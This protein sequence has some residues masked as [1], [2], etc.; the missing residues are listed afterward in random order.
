MHD[1]QFTA[2]GP[3][4]AGSGFDRSGFSTNEDGDGFQFGVHV[5]A[6]R[7]GVVGQTRGGGIAGVLGQ[8]RFSQ[9]GVMGTAF[10]QQT[11]VV[12]VS[13]SNTNDLFQLDNQPGDFRLESLGDGLGTG[14]LGKST[15]S[16]GVHG[17]SASNT[18]VF[19]E[20]ESG[21]GGHGKSGS[22][23]GVFGQSDTGLGVHGHSE[24]VTG[25]F[26]DSPSG[27]GVHGKSGSFNGVV[28]ESAT[29]IGVRGSSTDGLGGMFESQHGA[30]IRLLPKNLASPEGQISGTGGELV[31]TTSTGQSGQTFGLWFCTRGGDAA[32]AVWQ[33]VAGSRPFPG[34]LI[35]LNSKGIDVKRIQLQLNLVAAAGLVV[36]GD[37][38]PLTKQAV[39]NFQ[40][41][42]H[43]KVD[44][45][46]GP[47]TWEK[48]FTV[49]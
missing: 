18:G 23:T 24:H 12:G 1:D 42:Q 46:V 35:K 34:T 8:G 37:F 38:G 47:I 11:G 30:Q 22:N 13:V 10:G 25:V 14:V 7:C 39:V 6:L 28:G 27:F 44:G 17:I 21:F 33:L 40:T 3:P 31:A 48:L 19:G 2:T 41:A 29:G 5:N 45:I 49:V 16:L 32:K 4:F 26:G 20:S 9:F 36:D 15:K 43:I